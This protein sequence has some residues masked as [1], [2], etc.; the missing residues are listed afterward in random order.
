MIEIVS[1]Y[2]NEDLKWLENSPY[3]THIVGKKELATKSNFASFNLIPNFAKEAGSYLWFIVNNYDN[4]PNKMA[5][6]HGHEISSHQKIPIFE[7]IE[8][9]KEFP[10][11]DL[12]RFANIYL[13]IKP[14]SCYH[15]LWNHL[16]KHFFGEVPKVV[17]YRGMA[18]FL[19]RKEVILSKPKEFWKFLYDETLKIDNNNSETV[20]SFYESFWHIIF[21]LESPI[22][23]I[24]RPN[25][26]PSEEKV[27]LFVDESDVKEYADMYVDS[28]CKLYGPWEFIKAIL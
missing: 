12:N 24:S 3:P 4:L 23:D 9:Y 1:S 20:A 18:Q 14:N 25:F 17:N 10:F 13:F 2:F 7:A 15:Q 11:V 22:E 21:G 19:V 28:D 26:F 16:L 27:C 8:T 6:I 5:F